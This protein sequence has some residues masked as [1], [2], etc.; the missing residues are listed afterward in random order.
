MAEEFEYMDVECITIP[1]AD[2]GEM[3]CAI[4]DQFDFEGQG[5]IVLSP[6]DDD[7]VGEDMFLYRYEED[8]DEIV[9]DYIDDEDELERAAAYYE[10]ILDEIDE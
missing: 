4:I 7:Q 9:I 2:G 10:S 3:D 5:Y 6:I 8:G 1:L